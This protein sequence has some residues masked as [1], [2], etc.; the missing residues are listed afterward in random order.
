MLQIINSQGYR[1]RP[2]HGTEMTCQFQLVR[3]C[4]LDRYP[5][6]LSHCSQLTSL[7]LPRSITAIPVF[8]WAP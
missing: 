1:F 4:L 3:M 7:R 2:G 8:L 5:Q 6:L